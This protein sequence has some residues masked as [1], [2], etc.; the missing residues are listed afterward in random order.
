MVDSIMTLQD[1]AQA[2]LQRM[3]IVVR[4]A[5]IKWGIMFGLSALVPTELAAK[6]QTQWDKL[7]AAIMASDHEGV[8]VLAD[9]V[10]RGVWAL[11]AAAVA[12]G[13]VPGALVAVGV[14]VVVPKAVEAS[15]VAINVPNDAFWRGGGDELSF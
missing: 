9:G 11:D 12:A 15:S 14:G 6:F 10:V 1:R 5:E 2:H 4:A 13:H 7:S 8:I 3:D